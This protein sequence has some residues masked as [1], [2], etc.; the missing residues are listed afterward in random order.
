MGRSTQGM[1][2]LKYR[3]YLVSKPS[4]LVYNWLQQRFVFG[5]F[6]S[7]VYSTPL[8]YNSPSRMGVIR[9]Q[10]TINVY[11]SVVLGSLFGKDWLLH[12][13]DLQRHLKLLMLDPKTFLARL[14]NLFHSPGEQ[15]VD[16]GLE[17]CQIGQ[18]HLVSN[19]SPS[20]YKICPVKRPKRQLFLTPL[21][22]NYLLYLRCDAIPVIR[23]SSTHRPF[24]GISSGPGY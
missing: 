16:S 5:F 2:T 7:M 21:L 18:G 9:I 20:S 14:A 1:K 11:F 24:P 10:S 6:S 23:P 4:A 22:S 3:S 12:W 13:R 19:S 8:S 15:A 17:I